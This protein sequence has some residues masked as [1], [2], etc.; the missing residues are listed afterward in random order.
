MLRAF[1]FT[2]FVSGFANALP[3]A[4]AKQ[5]AV[6]N[7][8]V[9]NYYE[10]GDRLKLHATEKYLVSDVS[11]HLI[12]IEIRTKYAG[13]SNFTPSAKF[14][15]SLNDCRRAFSGRT[16][17]PFTIEMYSHTGGRWST[18]AYKTKSTAFEEK[19]NC[20]PI[21]Y[22]VNDS[23][24]STHFNVE[25][26]QWGAERLFQQKAKT[27]DQLLSYYFSDHPLLAGVAY[28]KE[29]NPDSP[30]EFEME[31]VELKR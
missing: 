8:W 9:W 5:F 2:F 12:T 1:L 27:P 23:R 29:F 15:A 18:D 20:N 30:Y 13:K 28:K 11:G 31:L 4:E 16:H 26:T 25:T 10:N 7:Y 21:E 24:Y 6:G 14:V 3:I 22:P 19:F 17:R